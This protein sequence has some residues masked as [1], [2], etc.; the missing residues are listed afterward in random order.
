MCKWIGVI[1]G[2]ITLVGFG[3]ST[4]EIVVSAQS[5]VYC[6]DSDGNLRWSF[7]HTNP[8]Y[9]TSGP[10]IGDIDSDGKP[11][12]VVGAD[13]LY[14]LSY[15]GNQK[16]SYPIEVWLCPPAIANVDT[17]GNAEVIVA[18]LDTL[19]CFNGDGS[20]KWTYPIIGNYSPD[21]GG[22]AVSV[23]NVD[24]TLTPEVFAVTPSYVYCLDS[25]GNLKW[26][27]SMSGNYFVGIAVAD[28]N[29]DND[30]EIVI[31]N[32]KSIYCLRNDGS[33]KWT[34]NLTA[35]VSQPAIADINNDTKPEIVV[36]AYPKI[37]ALQENIA[38]TGLNIVWEAD[39]EDISGGAS[40]TPPVICD[41]DGD[42][43]KDVIWVGFRESGFVPVGDLYILN[44]MDGKHPDNSGSPCYKD[45]NFAART[46]FERGVAVADIDDDGKVEIV[47][48]SANSG[49][50]NGVA[51]LEC[52]SWANSRKLFTSHLYH[53]TDI[54]DDVTVPNIESNNWQSH[55]TWLT[56]LTTGGSGFGNPILKWDYANAGFGWIIASIA[57]APIYNPSG[58][59]EREFSKDLGLKILYTPNGIVANLSLSKSEGVS[60]RIFDLAGRMKKVINLG[61][62]SAAIHKIPLNMTNFENGV[63]FVQT[64]IGDR[65]LNCKAI[66]IK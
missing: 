9:Q 59:E 10:A 47:G 1:L 14:C 7:P 4:S 38:G 61:T 18:E 55:N 16:W 56:Q 13:S 51:V 33:Q 65:I 28:L 6:L 3:Y 32:T 49:D 2:V 17:T 44:G 54:N 35:Y 37:R 58:T 63:Y 40:S 12:I 5:A 62:M 42:L 23:A 20:I 52:D 53:I 48:I 60:F 30:P 26:S 21:W 34:Y 31:S 15:D 57:I 19:Y 41:I 8:F 29:L 27:F 66:V 39:V 43:D 46:V 22:P 36:Y 64:R 24:A 25:N 50:I 11:E 45:T